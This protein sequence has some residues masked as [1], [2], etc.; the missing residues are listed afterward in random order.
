MTEATTTSEPPMIGHE[1]RAGL[2]A[3]IEADAPSPSILCRVR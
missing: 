1:D 3:R 2:R